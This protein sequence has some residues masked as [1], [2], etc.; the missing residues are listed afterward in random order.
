M[1]STDVKKKLLLIALMV[2]ALS[3]PLQ[4]SA[5]AMQN[6]SATKDEEALKELIDE[7]AMCVVKGDSE[8]MEMFMS[9]NFRGSAEGIAFGKNMLKLAL[10]SGQMKVG[11]WKIDEVKLS[12][13]GNSALAT[14]SSTLSNATYMGKDFSGKWTFTDRFV[15]QP[16]GSWRA[17][18]SQSRRTRR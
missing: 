14:G 17:I 8:G 1:R 16:D 3:L 9:D 15:R 7:W 13:K 2:A 11:D 4:Q 12:I 10:K 6:R 5:V 18:S